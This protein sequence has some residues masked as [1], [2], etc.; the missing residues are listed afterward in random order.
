[1]VSLN[2]FVFQD[3]IINI[4]QYIPCQEGQ[5]NMNFKNIMLNKAPNNNINVSFEL[6]I[7]KTMPSPVIVSILII[8]IGT[9]LE[10]SKSKRNGYLDRCNNSF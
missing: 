1:M 5:T 9:Y 3:V 10:K 6:E 7:L 8:C 2:L 4:D